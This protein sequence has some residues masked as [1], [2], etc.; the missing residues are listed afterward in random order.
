MSGKTATDLHATSY[1]YYETGLTHD[2]APVASSSRT[3]SDS[4]SPLAHPRHSP[5]FRKITLSVCSSSGFQ[6]NQDLFV[7]KYH[8][9]AG[10]VVDDNGNRIGSVDAA[11]YTSTLSASWHSTTVSEG[12]SF[13]FSAVQVVDL[14]DVSDVDDVSE[15]QLKPASKNAGDCRGSKSDKNDDWGVFQFE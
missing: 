1:C 12:G 4:P 6:W 9:R 5:V 15:Y 3:V 13:G 7:S 8:Q 2:P 14:D 11:S 10:V